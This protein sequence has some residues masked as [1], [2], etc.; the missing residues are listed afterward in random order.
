MFCTISKIQWN[1]ETKT[2]LGIKNMWSSFPGHSTC[3]MI[4]KGLSWPC[5]VFVGQRSLFPG[6]FVSRFHCTTFQGSMFV[7]KSISA[8]NKVKFENK[9][10]LW[11]FGF[12]YR[13][14]IANFIPW[15]F[16][17][18]ISTVLLIRNNIGINLKKKDCSLRLD[19]D[20]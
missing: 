14:K 2:T 6:V 11:S 20:L 18:H 9:S 15:T 8:H 17:T 19:L 13:T 12:E 7:W 1:L 3:D 16:L 4:M 10:G 5:E